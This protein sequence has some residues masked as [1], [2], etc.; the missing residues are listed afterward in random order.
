VNQA[1]LQMMWIRMKV[2]LM[3]MREQMRILMGNPSVKYMLGQY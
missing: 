2:I 3:Q 1:D